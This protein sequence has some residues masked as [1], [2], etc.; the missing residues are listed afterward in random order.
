MMFAGVTVPVHPG[1]HT[2]AAMVESPQ[3]PAELNWLD[4]NATVNE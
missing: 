4:R 3:G 1:T 2:Q